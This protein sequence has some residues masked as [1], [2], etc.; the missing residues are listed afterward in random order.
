MSRKIE[1]RLSEILAE[2]GQPY[3]RVWLDKAATVL[4]DVE[5]LRRRAQR[6]HRRAQLAERDVIR[7]GKRAD[8]MAGKLR[9]LLTTGPDRE[10]C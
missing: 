4:A 6:L 1:Q 8:I 9:R 5:A 7:E 2:G 10:N 3:D